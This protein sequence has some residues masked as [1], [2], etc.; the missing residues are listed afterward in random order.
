MVRLRDILEPGERVIA[1]TPRL[2]P[3]APVA[4]YLVGIIT[5]TILVVADSPAADDLAIRATI[6]FMA[7]LAFGLCVLLSL[8]LRWRIAVTDRR[9]I[10]RQGALRRQIEEMLR[11]NIEFARQVV[12]TYEIHG[13]GRVI[14]AP[15]HHVLAGRLTAILSPAQWE[16]ARQAGPSEPILDKEERVIRKIPNGLYAAISIHAISVA[17]M[18]SALVLFWFIR[19]DHSVWFL[20]VATLLPV[21]AMALFGIATHANA[22]RRWLITDR[23]VLAVTGLLYRRIE[24][25]PL[26]QDTETTLDEAG[27]T[28]RNGEQTLTVPTTGKPDQ[29]DIANRLRTAIVAA[30]QGVAS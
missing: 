30:K 23:R 20:F 8:A 10:A 5:G 7:V 27:L 9:V 17:F 2:W 11:D 16:S 24:Y 29:I 14:A 15:L 25:V 22:N 6:A 21:L 3:L 18:L 26:N 1:I 12:G 13:A 28:I 4:L 19:P